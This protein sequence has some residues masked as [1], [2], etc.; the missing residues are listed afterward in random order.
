MEAKKEIT[1][2]EYKVSVVEGM[3]IGVEMVNKDKSCGV[4]EEELCCAQW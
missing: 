1:C 2:I 3:V 4:Q